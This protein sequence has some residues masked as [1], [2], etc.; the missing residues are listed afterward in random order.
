MY[1]IKPIVSPSIS[2]PWYSFCAICIVR[3]APKPNLPED[4]CW[5]V[6][7]V[8][9]P[10]GF[11]FTVFVEMSEIENFIFLIWSIA[12]SILTLFLKVNFSIFWPLNWK[13]FDIIELLLLSLKFTFK[14]QNSWGLNNSISCSLSAISFNAT[15]WTR[16]ADLDPGSLVHK[17]GEILN[18]TK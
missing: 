12:S 2:I 16:P 11:R 17:I 18:P 9:G 13:R 10:E 3:D 7:V 1:V 14:D 6:D 5:S 8:N 15:D 4:T